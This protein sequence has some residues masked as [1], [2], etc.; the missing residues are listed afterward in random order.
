MRGVTILFTGGA[1]PLSQ[2]IM[3]MTRSEASHCAIGGLYLYEV[4]I[5]LHASVGGVKAVPRSKYLA[6][7]QLI[8][9]FEILKDVDVKNAISM[10][11]EKYDYPGLFGFFPIMFARW[12]GRKIRNP[13]SSPRA[14]VCSELVMALDPGG[15]RFPEWLDY[16]SETTTPEDLLEDCKRSVHHFRK[17]G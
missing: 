12:I 2:L 1:N 13:L 8:A 17:I 6:E 16:D 4:P 15:V 14:V 7:H 9:E 11:D 3:W 5:V 10:L